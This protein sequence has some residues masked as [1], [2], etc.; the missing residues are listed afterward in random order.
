MHPGA[1]LMLINGACTAYRDAEHVLSGHADKSTMFFA[2]RAKAF[3][4]CRP[5]RM[6]ATLSYPKQRDEHPFVT[7]WHGQ[8][9]ATGATSAGK[10]ARIGL[11]LGYDCVILCGC[12]MDP[13]AGYWEGEAKVRHDCARFD[14]PDNPRR[15]ITRYR[16]KMALLAKQEPFKSKVFSMSGYSKQVLGGPT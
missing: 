4:D 13:S 9:M 10:A 5:Y 1:S 6:H 2:E 15:V 16:E 14:T 3:P 12:P 11:A 8:A 7:D